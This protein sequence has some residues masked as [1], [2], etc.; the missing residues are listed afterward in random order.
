MTETM[1]DFN[2]SALYNRAKAVSFEPLPP[3]QYHFEVVEASAVTTSTGKPMIKIKLSVVGGSRSGT[4]VFDQ[5]VLSVESE[6]ALSMFFLKLKAF[7]LDERFFSTIPPGQ[8]GPVAQALF[9]KHVYAVVKISEWNGQPRNEVTTYTPFV[10]LGVSMLST[11]VAELA[12]PPIQPLVQ[13]PAQY[14]PQPPVLA[15][16][17][18]PM[19]A[20]DQYPKSDVADLGTD[21]PF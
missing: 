15:P 2:W 5:F 10:G 12:Q 19:Q 4:K 16:V 7:G 17:Q 3:A 21:L 11:P 9:G 1:G 6:K 18:P 14:Q 8:L 20:P 13:P